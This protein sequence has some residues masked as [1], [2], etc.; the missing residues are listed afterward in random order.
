LKIPEPKHLP[1]LLPQCFINEFIAFNVGFNFFVPESFISFEP[2]ATGL[3]ILITV[4]KGAITKNRCFVFRINK[5]WFSENRA[6]FSINN[7]LTP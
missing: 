6:M 7:P 4:P 3:A 1:T 2:M 5:I